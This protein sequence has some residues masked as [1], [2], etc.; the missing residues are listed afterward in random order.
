MLRVFY[1][2]DINAGKPILQAIRKMGGLELVGLAVEGGK[3][4]GCA[5]PV[6][7]I[8]TLSKPEGAAALAEITPDLFVNFNSMVLFPAEVLNVP[9]IAA[10]NFHPGPLPEYAGSNVYQWGV[11]N[12]EK[13]FGATIHEMTADIDAGPILAEKRF[14]IGEGDT[15]LIVYTKALSAG[16]EMLKDL[17]PRYAAGERPVGRNQDK[18]KR[19]YYSRKAPFG[20]FA[21]FAWSA[22]E[23]VNF[24]RALSYRPFT[25]PTGPPMTSIGQKPL[26]LVQAVIASEAKKGAAPGEV[27]RVEENGITVAAGD[28]GVLLTKVYMNGKTTA[29]HDAAETLGIAPGMRLGAPA[30]Q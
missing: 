24:V 20:C 3:A 18:G 14:P 30:A 8:T 25:S 28:A 26:E 22:R 17:L 19:R 4:E 12:G 5:E 10:L 15:G 2:G 11:I 13:E 6:L 29:A 9:K 16:V 27:L 23:V 21:S 7:D 1:A